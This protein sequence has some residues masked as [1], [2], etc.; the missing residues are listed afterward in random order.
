MREKPLIS[1]GPPK[2]T[3]RK[4]ITAMISVATGI[5]LVLIAFTLLSDFPGPSH[6]RDAN[7]TPPPEVVSRARP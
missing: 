4:L 6:D 2:R 7:P 5:V 1:S 3:D